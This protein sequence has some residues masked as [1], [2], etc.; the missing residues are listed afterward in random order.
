MRDDPCSCGLRR[1]AKPFMAKQP[2]TISG[3]DYRSF[4][5]R[6]WSRAVLPCL[7]DNPEYS[8]PLCLAKRG[9]FAKTKKHFSRKSNLIGIY[10]HWFLFTFLYVLKRVVLK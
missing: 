6:I 1:R 7:V 4:D 3:P 9:I 8:N 2:A 5:R 10:W